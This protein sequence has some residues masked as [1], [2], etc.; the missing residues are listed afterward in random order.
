MIVTITIRSRLIQ[1]AI[2]K[3]AS[4]LMLAEGVRKNVYTINRRT[5]K[6]NNEGDSLWKLQISGISGI[7]FF[8]IN[9]T[10][11]ESMFLAI[12]FSLFALS[13]I[14]LFNNFF[15]YYYVERTDTIRALYFEVFTRHYESLCLLE[16]TYEYFEELKEDIV[17]SFA[18]IQYLAAVIPLIE[19][20]ERENAAIDYAY[21]E[22]LKI[23]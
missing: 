10:F 13:I 11:I 7:P 8:T 16:R 15:L 23:D 5:V 17:L 19:E 3:S 14:L 1:E 21:T 12:S 9:D 4:N 20:E 2:C 18:V 6:S 22:M